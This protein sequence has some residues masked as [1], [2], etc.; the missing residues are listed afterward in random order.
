MIDSWQAKNEK[1][2]HK[3]DKECLQKSTTNIVLNGER[4]NFFPLKT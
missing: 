4:L 3:V 2:C 1:E